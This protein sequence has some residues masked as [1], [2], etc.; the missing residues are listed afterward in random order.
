[1]AVWLSF[2]GALIAALISAAVAL[3]QSRTDERVAQLNAD[4]Q[5]EV[6]RR[7]ALIDREFDAEAV[8]ARYREPLAAAAYDLQS[9][10]YNILT[11]DFFVR[12][13]EP[14][15]RMDEALR[16]TLFR[17]VQYFGWTEILRRDIQFLSFPTDDSTR[18]VAALQLKITRCLLT[19]DYG[20]AMMIWSDQQRALG[21]QM[22]VSDNGKLRCMGYAGFCECSEARF[23]QWTER[24]RSELRADEAQ[25]RLR[26]LQHQLCDL[27]EALDPKQLRYSEYLKRA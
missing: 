21:E 17:L 9:R 15:G 4:L 22:I 13:G 26:D 6:H 27:V 14:T 8:L 5:T 11:M 18:E 3:R 20:L 23:G 24:L 19:D 12:H 25:E 2:A 16:T 10:L 7:N 1:M